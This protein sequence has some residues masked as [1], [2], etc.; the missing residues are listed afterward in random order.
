VPRT[1]TGFACWEHEACEE[2]ASLGSSGEEAVAGEA[3]DTGTAGRTVAK[4]AG[5]IAEGGGKAVGCIAQAV[6]MVAVLVRFRSEPLTLAPRKEEAVP[7]SSNCPRS[8]VDRYSRIQ[9]LC[10]V[11]I[12]EV[13]GVPCCSCCCLE[14]T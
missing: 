7:E 3:V 11:N 1:P 5:K 8:A 2:G 6:S 12:L 9:I 14:D 4:R 13:E 10:F